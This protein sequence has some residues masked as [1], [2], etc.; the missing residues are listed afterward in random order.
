[1]SLSELL[2][3][4]AEDGELRLQGLCLVGPE[5]VAMAGVL[6][7]CDAASVEGG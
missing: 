2:Q 4:R 7:R 3:E 1:M 5:D 6:G